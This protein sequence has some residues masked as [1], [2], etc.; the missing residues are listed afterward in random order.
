MGYPTAWRRGRPS[1]SARAATG[2]G[3]G[4]RAP[5]RGTWYMP[6]R[7]PFRFP[8]FGYLAAALLVADVLLNRPNA[9]PPPGIPAGA[10]PYDWTGWTLICGPSPSPTPSVH[11][12]ET[13]WKF[14]GP[15]GGCLP[16][17]ALQR[18]SPSRCLLTMPLLSP[19]PVRIVRGCGRGQPLLCSPCGGITWWSRGRGPAVA[20]CR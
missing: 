16:R 2:F 10:R 6:R 11:G 14:Y 7:P 8:R 20:R 9:P 13:A 5:A 3:F 15:G 19:H 4:L 17:P 18:G 12:Y 1:G